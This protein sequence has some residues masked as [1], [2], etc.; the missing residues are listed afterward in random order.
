M[1]HIKRLNEEIGFDYGKKPQSIPEETEKLKVEEPFSFSLD[2]VEKSYKKVAK[3]AFEAGKTSTTT[4]DEWWAL[5]WNTGKP[6]E[7]KKSLYP[8]RS[9]IGF[10]LSGD[11]SIKTAPAVPVE[12]KGD[13]EDRP[14]RISPPKPPTKPGQKPP[15][16]P[17]P[18]PRRRGVWMD[19]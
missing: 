17:T 10:G 2:S 1:K 5:V 14:R 8:E 3:A 16:V 13:I 6:K 12:A 9:K 15:T 19:E 11:K 18:K 4:F 7:E